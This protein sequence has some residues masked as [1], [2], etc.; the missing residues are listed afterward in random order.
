M[1]GITTISR[2]LSWKDQ[3][4]T[5]WISRPQNESNACLSWG[6]QSSPTSMSSIAK[7]PRPTFAP[8]ED[9]RLIHLLL[10]QVNFSSMGMQGGTPYLVASVSFT[11]SRAHPHN[12]RGEKWSSKNEVCMWAFRILIKEHCGMRNVQGSRGNKF[13]IQNPPH[14]RPKIWVNGINKGISYHP[15]L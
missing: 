15:S 3:P 4:I 5:L 11:A 1:N 12:S 6:K 14:N 9:G 7:R 10:Q 13:R 8:N 2:A